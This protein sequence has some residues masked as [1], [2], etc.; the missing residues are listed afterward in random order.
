LEFTLDSRDQGLSGFDHQLHAQYGSYASEPVHE[1]AN[2]MGHTAPRRCGPYHALMIRAR[3]LIS[4]RPAMAG[5]W[6]NSGFLLMLLD[7]TSVVSHYDKSVRLER[8]DVFIMDSRAPIEIA[9]PDRTCAVCISID[10]ADILALPQKPE[11][12]F[13]SKIS[14]GQGLPNLLVHMLRGLL[15]DAHS[16]DSQ[17]RRVVTCSILSIID[18]HLLS[19]DIHR[20]SAALESELVRTIKT[21]I[22]DNL[23]EMDLDVTQVAQHFNMSRSSLY[24]LFGS[25][26]ETPKNWIMHQRL[27]SARNE[28]ADPRKKHLTISTICFRAG[29][30]DATHFSRLFRQTFGTSPLGYRNT[31]AHCNRDGYR[32]PG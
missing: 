17:E 1:P 24:R 27:L 10:R 14:G 11:D 19:T 28:L 2:A 12:L 9:I 21:W 20:R 18:Q 5:D 25:I 31:R 6:Q 3:N 16:Y 22:L 15:K 23:H 7:G 30:N 26:D 8:G 13:G 4:R 29:F 32:S